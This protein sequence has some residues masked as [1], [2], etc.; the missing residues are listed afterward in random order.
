[1]KR[2]LISMLILSLL[3]TTT[4]PAINVM[5]GETT[6]TTTT[7]TQSS[8]IRG[9]ESYLKYDPILKYDTKKTYDGSN[10]Y[11]DLTEHLDTVKNLSEGTI[12]IK[13]KSTVSN[14]DQTIFS[15]SDKDDAQSYFEIKLRNGNIRVETFENRQNVMSYLTSGKNYADGQWHTVVINSGELGTFLYVDGDK[16]VEFPNHKNKLISLVQDAD[17]MN[18]GMVV[19]NS[20]PTSYFTGEIEYVEVYDEQFSHEY[21]AKYSLNDYRSI[22]NII[23]RDEP[24]TIVFTGDSITHGVQYTKGYRSYSEHLKERL[25]G[26]SINGKVKSDRFVINTGVANGDTRYLLADYENWIGTYNADIVF[27]TLGMNDCVTMDL[28]T[29]KTNLTN[30]VNKIREKGGIPIIQTINTT[31]NG[32]TSRLRTLPQFMEG[33]RAVASQLDVFLIDHHKYW[34]DLGRGVTDAWLGDT[35]HPNEK[36]HLELM[37]LILRELKLDTEDSYTK[38]LA[39]PLQGN[40]TAKPVLNTITRTY[41]EYSSI[42]GKTP[43]VSYKVDRELYGSD[44]IDKNYDVNKVK[45]LSKG[46]IVTRFNLTSAGPAQTIISLSDSS[47]ASKEVAFGVSTNGSI[48][49]NRRT[50][51]GNA[52]FTTTRNGYNDGKWHTLVINVNESTTKVYVDGEIIHTANN[53]QFFSSL[54][55]PT[56]LSIGRNVHD[57]GG[58]WFYTGAIS[59]VDVYDNALTETEINSISA[60]IDSDSDFTAI[61]NRALDTTKVNSWVLVGDNSTTGSGATYGYKNYGEYFEECLRWENRGNKMENRSRFVVNSGIDGADSTSINTNFDKW[62]KEFDP[63]IISI[64]IGGNETV[65][66]A[67]FETNLKSIINKGKALNALVLLQTPVLQ[68]NDISNYVDVILKI[69]KELDVPVVDHYNTWKELEKDNPHIKATFL[70]ADNKLNHRGHL[71]VAQDMMKALGMYNA[72]SI[73]SGKFVDLKYS[74]SDEINNFKAQLT[75]LI[76]NSKKSIEDNKDKVFSE[77]LKSALSEDIKAAERE[78]EQANLP[79]E[80]IM[81]ALNYLNNSL[82]SFEDTVKEKEVVSEKPSKTELE[83]LMQSAEE[84]DNTKYTEESIAALNSAKEAANTVLADEDATAEEIEEAKGLLQA[85]INNLNPIEES[86]PINDETNEESKPSKEEL[87]ILIKSSEDLETNKYTKESLK[88]LNIVIEEAKKVFEDENATQEQIEAAE[89]EIE[90]ALNKLTLIEEYTL[91]GGNDGESSS[92]PSEITIPGNTDEA[93]N[94]NKT[95]KADEVNNITVIKAKETS[96]DNNGKGNVNLPKTGDTSSVAVGLSGSV[97]AFV[98]V[99]LSK[100]KNK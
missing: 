70:N 16:A 79:I 91:I 1:M 90:E 42:E 43:V 67:E 88:A 84:V 20:R 19:K 12:A 83:A 33:A 52:T 60:Q 40:G 76:N 57:Q 54:N 41:P 47:H 3:A 63:E 2:I 46:S 29:Y 37:N 22:L 36:G 23:N 21:A 77:E 53:K 32:A 13:F 35:I 59:Y 50:D 94:T 72:N 66:P 87:S 10:T 26:E 15:I 89:K 92:A 28:N 34:T 44:F 58:E 8:Q 7:T 48:F 95:G 62:V 55:S 9:Y 65:T 25:K 81:N 30:I 93:A 80:A 82:K 97:L 71:K 51:Q 27:V 24:T 98:G 45:S 68:Q 56:H 17:S 4:V 86:N 74:D 85:A 18:I 73:S 64:M 100:K 11:V 31:T 39:Y 75:T 69:A 38:K 61:R 96:K 6:T 99:L 14:G 49:V 5:A 78:V